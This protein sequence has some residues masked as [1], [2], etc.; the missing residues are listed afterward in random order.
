LL[1]DLRSGT[2]AS[3]ISARF[4]FGLARSVAQMAVRLAKQ[5]VPER[6]DTIVLSG[7]CFQNKTLFEACIS[8]IEGEGFCCLT[9]AQAPMNDGGLALGQAAI[10][11]ARELG[12]RAAGCAT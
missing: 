7:G 5:S 11:A 3:V 6:I 12:A 8:H 2:P 10:A 9:Q 1:E 4:H